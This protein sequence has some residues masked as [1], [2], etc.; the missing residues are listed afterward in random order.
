M[1]AD[2]VR[3]ANSFP[4]FMFA[5]I[6]RNTS[7]YFLYL[8]DIVLSYVTSPPGTVFFIKALVVCLTSISCFNPLQC[9]PPTFQVSSDF[10]EKHLRMFFTLLESSPHEGVRANL[11]IAAGDLCV[12]FPNL[13]EP[14]TAKIYARLVVEAF[15]EF[16]F[17]SRLNSFE[18]STCIAKSFTSGELPLLHHNNEL[19][20]HTHTQVER[21]LQHGPCLRHQGSD[22]THPERHDQGQRSRERNGAMHRGRERA[23]SSAGQE[24]LPRTLQKGDSPQVDRGAFP[25]SRNTF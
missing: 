1:R 24:V 17:L 25:Q 16:Y 11:T 7:L 21:L 18:M 6:L 22:V 4:H 13:L 10:C 14:W 2:C 9:I 20:R 8:L 19:F 3:A 15:F 12:R 5:L 23:D